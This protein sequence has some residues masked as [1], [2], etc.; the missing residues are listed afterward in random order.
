MDGVGLTDLE[1]VDGVNI[2]SNEYVAVADYASSEEQATD[3]QAQEGTQL[4][5]DDDFAYIE[6]GFIVDVSD[7]KRI[8][9]VIYQLSSVLDLPE[10][11]EKQICIK[12]GDIDLTSAHI[13]SIIALVETMNSTIA[14]ISTTSDITE[15]SAKEAGVK[16]SKLE[17]KIITPSFDSQSNGSAELERAL[18]KI[19]GG[20]ST[21]ALK[22]KDKLS[23]MTKKTT[24]TISSIA[25]D[26]N[27]VYNVSEPVI[28]QA[29]ELMDVGT[30]VD[31]FKKYEEFNKQLEQANQTSSV[32]EENLR[33]ELQEKL[34]LTEKLPTLYIQRTLR[35]GQSITADGNIVIV[36]DV[37]P[38][39]EIKAV[40]DITVWGIL[41]G[42]A[43][44]GIEGNRFAK[45]R[46]LKMNAIQIRISDVFAR[47]PDSA[48]IPY[49]QKT[50]VFVPEVASLDGDS[51]VIQKMLNK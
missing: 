42:I 51:I 39:S 45:I 23:Q 18:D 7:S 43:H 35:S 14:F 5:F 1:K 37:N 28:Q 47:R 22:I 8:S 27:T 3:A 6:N 21:E 2:G 12:M 41:G 50:D 17:N 10:A 40:G 38:G 24:D 20:V 32:E 25:A 46:A 11:H 30:E 19:F 4:R 34:V 33:R 31:D 36:G 26:N 49:I 29:P 13:S 48:N 16:V 15:A 9:D 44:A